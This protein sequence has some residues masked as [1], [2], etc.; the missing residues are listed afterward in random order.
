M[1]DRYLSFFVVLS[2][3]YHRR[4][5]QDGSHPKCKFHSSRKGETWSIM[6]FDY[7]RDQ[8]YQRGYRKRITRRN[9]IG[10]R[11]TENRVVCLSQ[12][13]VIRRD[14]ERHNKP[15]QEIKL[16]AQGWHDTIP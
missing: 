3:R 4:Q 13:W 7:A 6:P 14:A 9:E 5:G 15:C 8:S 11:K 12:D 16:R 10:D 1:G 2:R